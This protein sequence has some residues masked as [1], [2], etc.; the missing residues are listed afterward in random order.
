MDKISDAS[1][2]SDGNGS[3]DI[4]TPVLRWAETQ[5]RRMNKHTVD[6]VPVLGHG[7]A[8]REDRERE[9]R[10]H[11]EWYVKEER[12]FQQDMKQRGYDWEQD[13]P[14]ADFWDSIL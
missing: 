6:G 10:F 1:L 11:D 2:V 14:D 7:D 8:T 9:R 5:S 4:D 3:Q 12:R 13:R